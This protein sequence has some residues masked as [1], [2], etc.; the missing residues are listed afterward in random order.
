MFHYSSNESTYIR[1][2]TNQEGT[3]ELFNN[4]NAV[5][6]SQFHNRD[7]FYINARQGATA[8]GINGSITDITV[9]NQLLTWDQ[10]FNYTTSRNVV[11]ADIVRQGGSDLNDTY[12][13]NIQLSSFY[14]TDTYDA[15]QQYLDTTPLPP[16]ISTQRLAGIVGFQQNRHAFI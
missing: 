10:C 7:T 13:T 1:I 4:S 12:T 8:N 14:T 11:D 2:C 15:E 16:T 9:S 5:T 6:F 3:S